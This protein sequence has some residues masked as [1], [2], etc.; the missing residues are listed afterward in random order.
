MDNQGLQNETRFLIN[1]ML[2][3][4]I[5]NMPFDKNLQH[6]HNKH[7]REISTLKN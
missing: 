1:N 3:V 4:K 6:L 7:E 2:K 5:R